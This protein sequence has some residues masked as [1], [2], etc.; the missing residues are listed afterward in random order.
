M[1]MDARAS[2]L[3]W[4]EGQ[5]SVTGTKARCL[6]MCMCHV[7]ELLEHD[8][9]TKDREDVLHKQHEACYLACH[10]LRLVLGD[11]SMLVPNACEV[12]VEPFSGKLKTEKRN[13]SKREEQRK[14]CCFS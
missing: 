8:I 10:L 11:G 4:E 2:W 6:E 9:E 12:Q 7:F 1:L 13:R 5:S 14:I 3:G